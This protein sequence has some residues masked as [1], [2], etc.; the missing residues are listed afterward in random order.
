MNGKASRFF[1]TLKSWCSWRK[2]WLWL[3]FLLA[4]YSLALAVAAPRILERQLKSLARERLQAELTLGDISIHPFTLDLRIQDANLHGGALEQPLGFTELRINLQTS[5]LWHRTWRFREGNL[6]GVFGEFRRYNDGSSNFSRL[7][8]TW[9]ATAPPAEPEPPQTTASPSRLRVRDL[10]LEIARFAIHDQV[11]ATA[12][13]TDLGP[14]TL[15]IHNFNTLPD[16]TGRH[17]LRLT[18]DA[19]LKL[20]WQGDISLTPL[21]SSG[22]IRLSGPVFTLA[23]QYLQDTIL[24]QVPAGEQDTRFHYRLTRQPDTGWSL[25]LTDIQSTITQL[26]VRHKISREPVFNLQTLKLARGSLRWPE[27]TVEL[28][29]IDMRGGE[30]WSALAADGTLN[31]TQLLPPA[32]E[33]AAANAATT[34]TQPAEPWA[35]SAP[36]LRL[37]DW[38][39]H[40]SD[41]TLREPAALQLEKVQLEITGFNTRAGDPIQVQSEFSLGTGQVA[42]KGTLQPLPL[43]NLDLDFQLTALPLTLGQSY[44]AEHALVEPPGGAVSGAGKITATDLQ[45]LAVTGNFTVDELHITKRAD[46]KKILAWSQL[47]LE[48]LAFA[49]GEAA[50]LSIKKV[51]LTK[52]YADFAV[53]QDGTNTLDQIMRKPEAESQAVVPETGQ[54]PAPASADPQLQIGNMEVVD[55]SGIYSDL[56]LPLP[57]QAHI[58]HLNGSVSTLDSSSR[59]PAKIRLRGQVGEYGLVQVTGRLLPLAPEQNTQIA[60][61]FENVDIPDYSAYSVKFAGRQIARGRLDLDLNYEIQNHKM[62]GR[63]KL[64]LDNFALGEKIDHPG[65][66]DLPLDLAV[67]LMKDASGKI[68]LDLPV[69]GDTQDVQFD[70]QKMIGQALRQM[71]SSVATSPFRLLGKLAGSES[72]QFGRVVF[73]P[74]S[75]E[76]SPPQLEKIHQLANALRQRPDLLLTIPAGYSITRDTQPLQTAQLLQRV[77][78]ELDEDLDFLEKRH[79]KTLENL[80][81]AQQLTP[82]LKELRQ[83]FTRSADGK[84]PA[85]LDQLAYGNHL[86]NALVKIEILPTDALD[87][88]ALQRRTHIYDALLAFAPELAERVTQ[89]EIRDMPGK[90]KEKKVYIDLGLQTLAK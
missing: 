32:N 1:R 20:D 79:I 29:E 8:Q 76:I 86:Q 36:L 42:A 38:H 4:L 17:S 78:Q 66:L 44:I 54:E 57:F 14:L 16:Q 23:A 28:P 52:P 88:L 71:I 70:Y 84:A 90:E 45:H 67:A 3:A 30:L 11:P 56:S 85:E 41:R 60:V 80:F 62:T 48:E 40:W 47:A 31:L 74:G 77:Q 13:A 18:T 9:V 51:R 64:V 24:F 46:G 35:F 19:G 58:Q 7:A 63:N 33:E 73:A 59:T 82:T 27:Q 5:S 55:G 26:Q 15:H 39:I 53:A 49:A 21:I 81:E 34:A 12:F 75:K 2:P 69:S 83:Q 72:Q 22:D 65:A 87:N 37:R 68:T 61:Q 43:A 6:L 50:S 10:R 25:A 89:G